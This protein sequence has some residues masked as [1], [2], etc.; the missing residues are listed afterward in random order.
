[1]KHKKG[2]RWYDKDPALATYLESFQKMKKNLREELYTG[3]I[4]ILRENSSTLIDDNAM[5][6]PLDLPQRRWYDKDPYMWLI[7][8]GL[9]M[10]EKPL[11]EE[12]KKYLA[13]KIAA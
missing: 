7:F 1:M 10:A 9:R 6:F 12:I 5:E 13:S 11:L 8:N 4:E 3:I 2:N